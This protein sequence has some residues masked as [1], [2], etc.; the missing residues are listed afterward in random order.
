MALHQS[1]GDPL[2]RRDLPEYAERLELRGSVA[3]VSPITITPCNR[4]FS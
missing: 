2:A 1:G 4:A 3:Q